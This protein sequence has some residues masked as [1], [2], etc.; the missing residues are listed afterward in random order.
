MKEVGAQLGWEEWQISE[1]VCGYGYN[2]DHA[3]RRGPG[4][5]KGRYAKGKPACCGVNVTRELIAEYLQCADEY[6]WKFEY[7]IKDVAQDMAQ[8]RQQQQQQEQQR[9][10]QEQQR[11]QQRR[12]AEQ[13][14]IQERERREREAREQQIRQ[15][16][17]ERQQKEQEKRNINEYYRLLDIGK[18]ALKENRLQ[19]ALNS[20]YDARKLF[21]AIE[22]YALI[23][24]TL[25][26]SSNAD[27]H[28]N[29][30]IQ[31]LREYENCIRKEGKKLSIQQQ[32]WFARAYAA[33]GQNSNGAY[34]YS[35]AAELEYNNKNYVVADSIYKESY[36]KTGIFT[37]A[38]KDKF[39]M[40]AYSRSCVTDM[41]RDDHLFCLDAYMESRRNNEDPLSVT[42]G[43]MAW[44]HIQ[45]GDNKQAVSECESAIVFGNN[46][47]Y[48]YHNLVEAYMNLMQ[49]EKAYQ[50][51]EKMEKLK[52]SYQPWKKAECI[53]RGNLLGDESWSKA[54]ALYKNQ[55][56]FHGFH[57]HSCYRLIHIC[58]SD[59]DACEFGQ[60]FMTNEQKGTQMYKQA[61]ATFLERARKCGNK[62]YINCALDYN[63][64]EKA[65]IEKQRE[66]ER[67]RLERE[68]LER[69]RLERERLERERLER[70]R[71]ERE[72][73]EREQLEREQLERER[74]EREQLEREQL[75]REEKQRLELVKK[76]HEEELLLIIL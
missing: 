17:Y 10:Q 45:I 6:N 66:Q 18:K 71:L 54:E 29:S 65:W 56:A 48:V 30:I 58:K 50:T 7:F 14:A 1:V 51:F 11:E 16:E 39:F 40:L 12:L 64:E 53:Y 13:N 73:L 52:I 3:T 28:C 34:R 72:R 2:E 61:A 31:E 62:Q 43:N 59:Y 38:G 23:A 25:A 41:T 75:E 9:R 60:R 22:L 20:F 21:D 15:Q 19:Q 5:D 33:A 63:P 70:E 76:Q 42:M 36:K 57:S 4:K 27:T 24:E 68:R 49:F 8:S 55:I 47:P 35:L 69:E 44:H 32:L 46:E 74:L 37:N 67:Q 26:N